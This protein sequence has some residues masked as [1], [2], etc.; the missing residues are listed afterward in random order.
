[1]GLF[2]LKFLETYFFVLKFPRNTQEPIGNS[3]KHPNQ[4]S[5]STVQYVLNSTINRITDRHSALREQTLRGVS[6]FLGGL[7][8]FPHVHICFQYKKISFQNFGIFG[9]KIH[10][11]R[12]VKIF[13]IQLQNC[14][15]L[16]IQEL[17]N[18]ILEVKFQFFSAQNIF[19][20]AQ[21]FSTKKICF[22]LVLNSHRNQQRPPRI[23]YYCS[24]LVSFKFLC[25][26][27]AFSNFL[28]HFKVP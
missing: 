27:V 7:D 11:F 6:M 21:F 13:K 12:G 23:T 3:Q 8:V 9:T 24:V 5:N 19:R 20:C 18:I 1:M 26:F 10:D 28:R 17:K 14:F 15:K 16:M 4:I 25:V 22:L 2:F